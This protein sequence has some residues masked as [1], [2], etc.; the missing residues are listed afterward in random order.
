MILGGRFPLYLGLSA[1][2]ILVVVVTAGLAVGRFFERQTLAYEE[3][4]TATAVEYQ[5]RQHL[6]PADFSGP[7]DAAASRRFETVLTDLNDVFRLKA[8]AVDGRIVW[9]NER[10]LIGL[11]FPQNAS[12]ARAFEGRVVT[13]LTEPRQPEHMFERDRG[14]VAE[15]YVPITFA[16]DP[17]IAGVVEAYRDTT[18]T[19]AGIRRVQALIWSVAGAGG[20]A[21]WTVLAL[22]VWH[23]SASERRTARRLARQNDELMLLQTFTASVVRPLT[24][25]DV[26]TSV[27]ATTG[28]GLGLVRTALFRVEADATTRLR[29]AWPAGERVEAPPEL[30]RTVVD[31]RR[32]AVA[33]AV[34]VLPV[35]TADGVDHVFVAV[36]PRVVS[37]QS[38]PALATLRIMVAEGAIALTNVELYTRIREAHERLAAILAAI[39]D[40]MIIVDAEMRVVWMNAA[41]TE[42]L[43]AVAPAGQPCFAVFGETQA[44]DG[45]PAARAL[46]TG[47]VE[48]GVRGV[49]S[50]TGARYLDLVAAPL[51]DASGR[52]YQVLEMAR[53]ITGLVEMEQ[54]LK[55]SAARLE[56]SHAE[57]SAKAQE[58][59]DANRALQDAQ[60][61]LVA[62]ERLAA[63]GEVVVGL[64]HAILNPLAGTLGAL[65]VLKQEPRLP[66]RTRAALDEAEREVR[67]I[68]ALVRRLPSVCRTDGTPY[69]GRTTMLDVERALGDPAPS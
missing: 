31:H 13:V 50:A 27:V 41:A 61:Q 10:R 35:E 55:Q 12:L 43:D 19:L 56:A 7:A 46:H 8:F 37:E 39:A 2:V 11:V 17:R 29:A 62:T 65:Q 58:L 15:I 69:V 18:A 47:R 32:E 38:R 5:A 57:L 3:E 52:V 60:A 34:A 23:A 44:C 24:R 42:A 45:C 1:A 14:S 59:E 48:R 6:E 40:R 67:R 20:L 22:V 25:G 64:H 4:Q 9:S 68:E 21:L 53:D 30:V 16:G 28:A 26:P 66:E 63:V 33:G 54:R 51:R 49:P 36:F